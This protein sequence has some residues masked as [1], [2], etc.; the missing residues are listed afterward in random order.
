[1]ERDAEDE[2]VVEDAR[3]AV[4]VVDDHPANVRVIELILEELDVR[5]IPAHS[6]DE[7]LRILLE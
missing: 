3:T 6:G 4:L 7:A 5:V 1:M 2:H